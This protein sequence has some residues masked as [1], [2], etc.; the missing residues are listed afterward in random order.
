MPPP[1][2][3][4]AAPSLFL[5]FSLFFRTLFSSLYL[6]ICRYRCLVGDDLHQIGRKHGVSV[7]AIERQNSSEFV[8]RNRRAR[9]AITRRVRLNLGTPV[10][11]PTF[12]FDQTVRTEVESR[13]QERRAMV[14]RQ[15]EM[16]RRVASLSTGAV[17]AASVWPAGVEASPTG[18]ALAPGDRVTQGFSAG[19][20]A[21]L[22]QS[23][24]GQRLC[25]VEWDEMSAA[26]T[27]VQTVPSTFLCRESL[28]PRRRKQRVL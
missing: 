18:I 5:S 1:R 13:D 14:Q 16:Q 4:S 3:L 27:R 2:T 15:R 20:V 24:Q 26:A 19:V 23:P 28:A 8:D 21:R 10:W 7:S 11:I 9:V 17:T 25:V 6:H 22:G 12:A